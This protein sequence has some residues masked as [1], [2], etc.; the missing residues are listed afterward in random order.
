[1]KWRILVLIFIQLCISSLYAQE[2]PYKLSIEPSL[3]KEIK[4][5]RTSFK[6]TTA[7]KNE[8]KRIDYSLKS[9]GYINFKIISDTTEGT[10][11]KI[12][13][14]YNEI[15]TWE[16][17]RIDEQ[18]QTYLPKN[19]FNTITAQGKVVKE[20]ILTESIDNILNYAEDNGYPFAEIY[21]DSLQTNNRKV[22]AILRL[23]LNPY[24][25]FDT[26]SIN[27]KKIIQASFLSAYLGIKPGQAYC[28]KKIQVIQN[29]IDELGFIRLKYL[30]KIYFNN[31]KAMLVLS[32][33][34]RNANKFDGL[35]GVQPSANNKK[36][37]IVGQA[38]LYLVN[39]LGRAEKLQLEFRSQANETRDLKVMASYPFLFST[40]FGL[41]ANIDIRRQ[42]TSFSTLGRSIAVQYL[43]RGNNQVSLIYKVNES[44]LLSVKKY[45]G[46]NTLPENLDVKKRSYGLNNLMEELDYRINPTKG[47]SLSSTLLFGTREV[48]RNAN[49]AD[50]LY[51]NIDKSSSQLQASLA[52]RKFF[53]LSNKNVLLVSYK[54]EWIETE[55][56]FNNELMRFGGINDLRGFDEEGIFAS[57]YWVGTME[58]RFILDRNSFF[59]LFYDQGYYFNKILKVEDYPSGL[60]LGVQ[61]QTLA[62]AL[63]LNYALGEQMNSGFNFQSGKIHFGIINYF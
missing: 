51:K 49:F 15:W 45:L 63:Q 28:E 19:N 27:N 33:E 29:R 13:F 16:R 22:S 10:L 17:L 9:A 23:K 34:K 18:M 4:G 5:I 32:P 42:D 31:N 2:L 57:F 41:S 1:M 48:K 37:A 43:I 36:T 38:Q 20:N 24:I 44:S 58:Y 25:Q 12:K 39:T 26:I 60:G 50:S 53:K 21:F 40:S 55:Q 30:P 52:V 3:P 47:Y 61:L 54:T 56:L 6:D 11:R 62:G 7:L 14:N 8:L 46:T 59:R 35:I